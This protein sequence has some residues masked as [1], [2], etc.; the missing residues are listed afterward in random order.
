MFRHG[1]GLRRAVAEGRPREGGH[2]LQV[3][4]TGRPQGGV[5]PP[6]RPRP[7]AHQHVLA[8]V[9]GQPPAG[10]HRLTVGALP[11]ADEEEPLCPIAPA[12]G[13]RLR[14][15]G[16]EDS[17]PPVLRGDEGAHLGGVAQRGKEGEGAYQPAPLPGLKATGQAG[18]PSRRQSGNGA[19][20][21]SI[22]PLPVFPIVA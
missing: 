14:Q 4:G 13:L 18:R 22:I 17:L 7:F 2:P 21:H 11:A 16:G 8:V 10:G 1:K 9:Q 15:E 19:D 5:F 6:L 12:G 3:P 20:V